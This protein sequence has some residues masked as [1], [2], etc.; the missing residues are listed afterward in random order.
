MEEREEFLTAKQIAGHKTDAV[1]SRYW[2]VNEQDIL[3]GLYFR[4]GR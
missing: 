1:Y 2:I 3:V 4:L